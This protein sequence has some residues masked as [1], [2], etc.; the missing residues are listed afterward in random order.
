MTL[1]L[2]GIGLENEKDISVKGL[3]IVK[4]CDVVYLE[5][6][7]SLLQCSAHDLAKFYGKEIVLA[8]RTTSEQGDHTIVA[9]AKDKDVAFLVIG[10]PFS[11]T[12]HIDLFKLAKEENVAV[13]VVHNASILNAIGIV[14]LQLYKYGKT[15]SIPYLDDHPNL[16]TPYRIVQQNKRIGAHT[17]LLLDIQTHKDRFMSVTEAIVVLEDIEKRVGEKVITDDLRV[18]G[19]AR[20]GTADFMVKAGPLSEMKKIDFGKPPHCLIIP[21]KM[22]FIEEEMLEL[23]R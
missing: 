1:Y 23:W 2:I 12:T 15:T 19:C 16:E 21:G 22:H 8:D 9:E 6:Y 3:D 18:V 11:A 5:R 14:G 13:E 20:L 4:K 7:T 17:L 10:D